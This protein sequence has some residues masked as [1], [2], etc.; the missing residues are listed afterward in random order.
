MRPF[1][2]SLNRNGNEANAEDAA[3]E[4]PQAS[5]ASRASGRDEE[6]LLT[7]DEAQLAATL[8]LMTGFSQGCC[9]AHRAPMAAKVAEQLA[10][11]AHGSEVS[12]DMRAFFLRLCQRW[13]VAADALNQPQAP[14]QD[15]SAAPASA[16]STDFLSPNVLWHAPLETLQ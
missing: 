16:D 15:E 9:D 14:T 4:Q 13:S 12:T 8:A 10:R 2:K 5:K 7:E 1:G 11:M 3:G 6:Y